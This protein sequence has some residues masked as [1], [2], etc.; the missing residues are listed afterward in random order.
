MGNNR[1]LVLFVDGFFDRFLD[2]FLDRNWTPGRAKR[3]GV[4]Y[5]LGAVKVTLNPVVSAGK[6]DASQGIG[7]YVYVERLTFVSHGAERTGF[8]TH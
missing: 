6:R 3:N 2:R 4:A 7:S 5:P 1:K 8:F